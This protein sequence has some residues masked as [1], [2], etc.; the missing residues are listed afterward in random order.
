[1]KQMPTGKDRLGWRKH[2]T[3]RFD[4]T[5]HPDAAQLSL[6]FLILHLALDT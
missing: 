5:E 3:K 1:M 6:W 4:K 2:Y